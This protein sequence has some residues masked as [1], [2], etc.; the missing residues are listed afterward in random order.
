MSAAHP[1]DELE[2]LRITAALETRVAD[3]GTRAAIRDANRNNWR[4]RKWI[5]ALARSHR[6]PTQ[7][8]T[9]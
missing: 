7:E 8:P 5:A 4:D 6:I 3:A 2:W 1:M 9:Q